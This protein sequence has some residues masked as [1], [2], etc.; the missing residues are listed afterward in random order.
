[1]KLAFVLVG[2]VAGLF[3][4][5]GGS[6]FFAP[7][8][9]AALGYLLASLNDVGQRLKRLER[10][11]A[12]QAQKHRVPPSVAATGGP[13]P[14]VSKPAPAMKPPPLRPK[15]VTPPPTAERP[16]L[17]SF[18]RSP[19]RPRPV[20]TRGISDKPELIDRAWGAAKGWLTT[21]NVPVKLG[22]IISFFGV[23]FF[24]KYA[25]DQGLFRLP[26]EFRLLGVAVAG[27]IM[28]GFGWHLRE[29]V[30]IYALSLQGGGL[31]VMYLTIFSAMR[32]YE[33][34]PPVF[35]FVLL[36]VLTGL[37]GALAVLQ[38]SRVLAIFGIV[39]GFMAPVLVSTGQGNH[40]ILFSYYLVLNFAILGIA[41][42]KAWREL[43]LLGFGFT[44]VIGSLWGYEG[45]RPEHF[46]STQPFLI[47]YFL[48]YQFIAVLFAHRQPV[49]LRGLVDGTLVFG[50]PVI[51]FA[52]QAA[53]VKDMEYGLAYSAVAAALF[54][55]TTATF[56][57]RRE[58]ERMRLLVE[59]FAALAVAFG[60]IAIPLAFD[61]RWTAAAWALE[62]A[63]LVWVGL[64]QR[65]ILPRAAGVLLLFGSGVAFLL[66]DFQ[67][68]SDMPILNGDFLGGMLISLAALFSSRYLVKKPNEIRS[69]E[70][71]VANALLIWGALWWLGS[72][73]SEL[74]AQ[75]P[76]QY[77][78]TVLVLF[79]SLTALLWT[80]AG[81]TFDWR[82]LQGASMGYL[83]A[84]LFAAAAFQGQGAHPFAN[85][86]WIAWT[87]AFSVQ[88]FVLRNFNDY[89]K[90]LA[91]FEHAATAI[92]FV[93]LLAWELAWQLDQLAI[94]ELWAPVAASVLLGISAL[95]I[96]SLRDLLQWPIREHWSTY[97]GAACG[98]LIGLEVLLILWMNLHSS[99]DPAPLA[100]IPLLNP[101]D[102]ASAFA[103]LAALTWTIKVRRT[104][105]L[106]SGDF[107]RKAVIALAVFGFVVSTAAVIRGVHHLGGVPW[108]TDTLFDSVLVHAVLSIY[109]G[110]LGFTGMIWGARRMRRKLWL[111]GAG[112]MGVVVVKLVLIDLGDSGTLERIISFV[113]TGLLLVVV[114]YFAP[115][116]PRQDSVGNASG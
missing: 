37:I 39:G 49:N 79:F 4:S 50:T 10:D 76:A 46:N 30:R 61:A 83:F 41:W 16:P 97:A 72:G 102:L 24:L 27:L 112:V 55:A 113:A 47:I 74:E 94:S 98:F 31:G 23:A 5:F 35:A 11:V 22:V 29:R 80:L 91:R 115:V 34:L 28:L 58:A 63:A 56:L 116:P 68:P 57:Y 103:V 66:Q 32:L 62:G 108:R 88:Y 93:L 12:G 38:D 78:L 13:V 21:G 81:R 82:Q 100:Y 107:Q 7:L 20:A 14:T 45:Y 53:L 59:S 18:D 36:L 44:F 92:F 73:V 109:W 17:P 8:V 90:R 95:T 67:S 89:F 71:L 86:G 26:I 19:P 9:G 99:G 65:H 101:L 110:L 69:A 60:T 70:K 48:F 51:A 106:L 85:F 2:F 105:D 43:N 96:M 54:Y 114:G 25:V 87:I 40:V 52:L 64:R 111:A 75:V 6:N 3:F 84:L 15:P 104:T 33:V 77:K 42:F 1:M